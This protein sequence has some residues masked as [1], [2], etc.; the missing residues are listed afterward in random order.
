MSA[1]GS[2]WQAPCQH[3]ASH[4]PNMRQTKVRRLLSAIS[5]ASLG[6]IWTIFGH[7]GGPKTVN[8]RGKLKPKSTPGSALEYLWQIRPIL[9]LPREQKVSSRLH[10][11]IVSDFLVVS[12][13][14]HKV[15]P[16]WSLCGEPR[17]P[18]STPREPRGYT[19]RPRRT[20]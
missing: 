14:S 19:S 7:P 9:I 1:A 18:M 13:W 11:S 4:A 15:K 8:T 20:S 5:G 16:L 10:A 17:T 2:H 6:T 3:E 12:L